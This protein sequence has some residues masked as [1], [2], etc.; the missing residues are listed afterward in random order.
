MKPKIILLG[1]SR[2][3]GKDTFFNLL[4]ELYPNKFI[5]FAFADSLKSKLNNL[6]IEMF[7]KYIGELNGE[8]K[9]IM[10]P[11]MIEFGRAW[12]KI[13]PLHWPKI[14]YKKI[15]QLKGENL[16]FIPCCCD[17]RFY[18]E[19]E[20]FK[21]IYGSECIFIE[22]NRIGAPEPTEEEK[23]NIPLLKK[24]VDYNL[25]WPTISDNLDELK[26]YVVK[27]YNKYFI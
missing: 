25:T 7:N 8:Q 1:M 18:N 23:K 17:L 13:D 12:R 22:I 16:E 19:L 6:S 3:V 26:P 11:I 14:V 20:F 9:E 24:Y 5:R 15:L 4:N 2:M 27:F 21:N 10:R